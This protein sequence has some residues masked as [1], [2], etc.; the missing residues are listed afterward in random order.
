MVHGLGRRSCNR[1]VSARGVSQGICIDG[2]VG[3]DINIRRYVGICAR[4]TGAGVAPVYK[5]DIPDSGKLSPLIRWRHGSP[6]GA[7]FL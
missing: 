1:P 4:I 3:G 7:S 6:S 2:E 5:N